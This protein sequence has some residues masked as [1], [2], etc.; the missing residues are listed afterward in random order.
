MLLCRE[1]APTWRGVLPL[2]G[3]IDEDARSEYSMKLIA[4]LPSNQ[5][6]LQ[7]PLSECDILNLHSPQMEFS[8][9]F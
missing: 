2:E 1:T 6:T 5:Q 9:C 3:C 7:R 8:F 4:R